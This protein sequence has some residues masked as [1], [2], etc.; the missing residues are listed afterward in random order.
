MKKIKLIEVW[1]VGLN[2]NPPPH[3]LKLQKTDGGLYAY[4]VL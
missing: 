2:F 1:L 4:A 3:K